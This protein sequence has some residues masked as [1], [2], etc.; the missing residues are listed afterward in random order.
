MRFQSS[1]SRL[2]SAFIP[3]RC[4]LCDGFSGTSI[5]LCA[6]CRDALPQVPSPCLRCGLPL[7]DAPVALCAPCMTDP[8]P[9]TRVVAPLVYAPPAADAIRA[10]KF[11]GDLVAT[12]LFAGLLAEE[13]QARGEAALP[14]LIVPVPLHWRRLIRRGHN[15]ASLIAHRL[16]AHLNLP[17]DRDSVR[18]V[19]ATTAQTG[20]N[21]RARLE[22]LRDAFVLRSDFSKLSEQRVAI[23]DDVM[24]TGATLSALSH[25]LVEGG[26]VEVQ[27]WVLARTI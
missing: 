11:R 4:I 27:A 10:I 2:L 23:V 24:T 1:L 25:C 14:T 22:N 3:G 7:M 6:P 16:G 19:R 13:I 9:F 8:P 17:V 20:L 21:R 26:A 18:R 5:D 15:Q 12:R